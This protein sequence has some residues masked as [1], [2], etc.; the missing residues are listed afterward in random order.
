MSCLSAPV[1]QVSAISLQFKIYT[2]VYVPFIYS[3][4]YKT[5]F[6]MSGWETLSHKNILYILVCDWTANTVG[7]S[8]LGPSS[9]SA[10]RDCPWECAL[11]HLRG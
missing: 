11:R 5:E 4:T 1:A 2:T 8:R 9:A 3:N 6:P 7:S 10:W